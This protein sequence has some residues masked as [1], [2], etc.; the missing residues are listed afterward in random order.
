MDGGGRCAGPLS[1]LSQPAS[2]PANAVSRRRHSGRRGGVRMIEP[3]G[4]R[5]AI[6]RWFDR[7]AE[8]ISRLPRRAGLAATLVILAASGGYGAVRGGHTEEVIDFLRDVR[9]MAANTIGFNIAAVALSG[10]HHLNREEILATAGVTGRASLLFFDVAD[11]RAR[12]KTNPWIADA[13][14]QKLLPDRLVISITERVP[15][16]LWQKEGRIGVIAEDGTVLDPYVAA[17]YA[18]LPLV[19][20]VGAELRAA[21]FLRVLGRFAELRDRVSAAGLVAERRWNLRLANGI[22]V[23]LPEFEV[24]KALAQLAELDRGGKLS[25]RGVTVIDLRL[26]DRV[27]VQL[28]DAAAQARDEAIKKKQQKLKGGAA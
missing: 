11:A 5:R 13:A 18:K 17:A 14:V 21:E 16:A 15:F 12:L 26:S 9:D 2:G 24:D 28:S 10:Q 19:V 1:E 20:G 7:I 23:R 4:R 22:D 25:G 8:R 27:T 6:D 3:P